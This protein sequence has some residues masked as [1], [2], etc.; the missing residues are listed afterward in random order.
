MTAVA[1]DCAAT[2]FVF[3]PAC[4]THVDGKIA[5]HPRKDADET[6]AG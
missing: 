2:A 4:W 5:N 1:A 6:L 3:H